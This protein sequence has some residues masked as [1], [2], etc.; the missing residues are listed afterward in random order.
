MAVPEALRRLVV[1]RRSQAS[2]G[3]ML[4]IGAAAKL[5]QVGRVTIDT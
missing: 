2:E 3:R 5:L 1:S 4:S